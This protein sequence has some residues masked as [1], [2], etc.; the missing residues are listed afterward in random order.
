MFARPCRI[1]PV[2]THA[3]SRHLGLL[4]PRPSHSRARANRASSALRARSAQ[5]L[6]TPLTSVRHRLHA[7]TTRSALLTFLPLQLP[8]LFNASSLASHRI[9]SCRSRSRQF[10]CGRRSCALLPR[11]HSSC[12]AQ[13]LISL[14]RRN[15]CT[16]PAP[17]LLHLQ[18][19]S[20]RTEPPPAFTRPRA[21]PLPRTLLR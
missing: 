8:Y 1:T 21:S 12:A 16:R 5:H 14:S 9:S 6:S 19:P 18:I 3:C 15:C 10:S 11:T 17:M 7:R 20:A 13:L 4:L 2:L